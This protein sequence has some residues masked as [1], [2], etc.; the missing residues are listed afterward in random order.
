LGAANGAKERTEA[1][2][3]DREEHEEEDYVVVREAVPE[4]TPARGL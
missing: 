4:L 3:A 1:L 2:S